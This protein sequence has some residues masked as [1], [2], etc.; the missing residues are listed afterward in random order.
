MRNIYILGLL[1]FIG[2]NVKSQGIP[3][4]GN[5]DSNITG[6]HCGS[7][8]P[9]WISDDG[10][11]VSGNGSLQHSLENYIAS[12]GQL[13]GGYCDWV[14]VVP[15]K[16][17]QFKGFYKL[18]ANSDL[19]NLVIDLYWFTEN[20]TFISVDTLSIPAAGITRDV[21]TSFMKT[22]NSPTNATKLSPSLV[23][24]FTSS[25]QTVSTFVRWDDLQV[26]EELPDGIFLN[27]FE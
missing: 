4:G 8:N 2:S 6:W 25:G 16:V 23:M 3:P 22:S 18:L 14:T 10:S 13:S 20:E 12:G 21:W 15:E 27:G 11:S 9:V 24:E 19:A 1:I 17:Y 26:M 5:F 7:V